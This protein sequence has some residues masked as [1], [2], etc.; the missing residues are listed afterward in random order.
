MCLLTRGPF[1]CIRSRFRFNLPIFCYCP[2]KRLEKLRFC[3]GRV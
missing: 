1:W 2:A 3:V